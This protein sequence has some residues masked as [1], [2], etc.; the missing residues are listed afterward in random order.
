MHSF[1]QPGRAT[2]IFTTQPKGFVLK[3]KST[4]MTLEYKPQDHMQRSTALYHKEMS[5]FHQ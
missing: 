5:S 4:D 1:Q 3:D 2:S